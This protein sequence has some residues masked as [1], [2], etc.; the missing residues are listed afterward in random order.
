MLNHSNPVLLGLVGFGLLILLAVG[1]HLG[2]RGLE[3]HPVPP[4]WDH[5]EAQAD[6]GPE[7]IRH[8][9][10]GACHVV[11]GVREARGRVGP[12]L[13]HL[14]AQAFI[15]G[16]LPNTPPNLALWIRA[17][18]HV[19][20]GSAMPDLGVTEQDARDIAAYLYLTR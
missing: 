2:V 14:R 16:R 15:A 8:Y 6:R 3:R 18:R 7:L 20:P 4:L 13:T 17:P 9:G 1:L 10:C 12:E 5:Y 11:P 19:D